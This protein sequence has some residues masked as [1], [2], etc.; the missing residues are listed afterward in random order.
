[1]CDILA[2]PL[3]CALSEKPQAG[4]S[5]RVDVCEGGKVCGEVRISD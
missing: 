3:T 2:S 1:M 5:V 4:G